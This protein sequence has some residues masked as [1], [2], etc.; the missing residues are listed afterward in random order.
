MSLKNI[1][2]D[3]GNNL[4]TKII[5]E[6]GGH[7][8]DRNVFLKYVIDKISYIIKAIENNINKEKEIIYS[9]VDI[10]F[11]KNFES[12][13]NKYEEDLVFQQSVPGFKL[14]SGFIII[15][16]NIITLNFFQNV[17]TLM[18]QNKLY[19]QTAIR[20]LIYSEDNNIS[21]NYLPYDKYITGGNIVD[22]NDPNNERK[23]ELKNKNIYM[24]HGNYST[25]IDTKY[26]QLKF[27]WNKIKNN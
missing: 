10:S 5:D 24:H 4:H 27:V 16:P 21:Y 8:D 11:Y 17:K 2:F 18:I 23:W 14:N 22:H 12:I 26:N 25:G 15:K 3:I 7:Y 1:N 20:E 9:D 6:E 13:T 19:D